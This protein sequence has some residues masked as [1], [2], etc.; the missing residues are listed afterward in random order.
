MSNVPSY[1]ALSALASEIIDAARGRGDAIATAESCTGG[2]VS[3]ALT[4]VPGSSDVFD[5]GFI[6]YTNT[7]KS[8]MLRVPAWLIAA[9]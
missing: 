2:L 9:A 6:T 4:S 5:R 1:E 8:E 3:A 7:A